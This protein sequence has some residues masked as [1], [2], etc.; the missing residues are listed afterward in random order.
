[1]K[2]S[3]PPF[4][5]VLILFFLFLFLSISSSMNAQ[6]LN[7]IYGDGSVSL[8]LEEVEGQV[9]GLF[10]DSDGSFY[11]AVFVSDESGLIGLLGDYYAVIPWDNEAMILY[12]MPKDV[13]EDPI[14]DEAMEFE[15]QFLSALENQEAPA[16][17]SQA[18]WAPIKRFGS[19]FYPSY[20]LATST[21]SQ[22]LTS[23]SEENAYNYY[24]DGN[25]YFGIQITK[26]PIGTI[27]RVEIEG[28]P[29]ARK[30]SYTIT[31]AKE[32]ITEIFPQMEY[33]YDALKN[34]NQAKPVN[35]K[36]SIY[37]ND[38]LFGEHME[39][40]WTRSV[41]DAVY[42]GE[43]HHGNSYALDFIFAAYVNENEPQ[44][45]AVLG[46]ML[47][48][49]IINSWN[50]YQG[51]EEDVMKQV[52]TM[53]Y[54]FQK[55]GFRYSSI[56]TQSGSDQKTQGQVV[57]FVK[58]ALNSSQ[59]NC[60]DGTV[61]FASFLYK[62]GIDVSIVL[63]PGHAYL[64]FSFTEDGTKR[65]ALETT[66]MGN[67]DIENA[68]TTDQLSD[69]D[70]SWNSFLGALR[71]GTDEY[72]QKA[73]PGIQNNEPYYMEINIKEARQRKVRPIK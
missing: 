61:L 51:S 5:N 10:V 47:D 16:D 56:T 19:D 60:I 46:E 3:T 28:E 48:H 54:H 13:N 49:K 31:V 63:V 50:G 37:V 7:G 40:L 15:L 62:I 32:G 44:L 6:T 8:H 18:T 17:Y 73:I 66:M 25:G 22:N 43:D 65:A 72:M 42:W 21:W 26:F 58:D 14:W 27:V 1:M 70:K 67:L 23:E 20:V 34:V 38:Q 9:N 71:Y 41:N 11:E 33:D 30:S 4:K 68:S 53:W 64:S 69:K 52:F 29:L 2:Q 24:G 55:K 45:D 36:Y 39:V 12:I 59:A 57:R 35:F